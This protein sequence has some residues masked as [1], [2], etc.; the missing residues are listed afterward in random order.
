MSGMYFDVLIASKNLDVPMDYGVSVPHAPPGLRKAAQMFEPPRKED[1][2]MLR[3]N[4]LHSQTDTAYWYVKCFEVLR[5][6]A[7]RYACQPIGCGFM[8]GLAQTI[9]RKEKQDE[10]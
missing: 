3:S 5:I 7:E 4:P 6:G 1:V 10:C 2:T 8:V 9:Y